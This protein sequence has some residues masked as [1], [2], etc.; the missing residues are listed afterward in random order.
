MT[1]RFL[2]SLGV[3]AFTSVAVFGQANRW[4]AEVHPAVGKAIERSDEAVRTGEH[5]LAIALLSG[6]LY[7]DGITVRLDESN[8]QGAGERAR[9]AT[10][11]AVESW[12]R[13][14]GNDSP[15]RLVRTGDSAAVR[16]VLVP[17]LA[18]ESEDALG[19]INLEKSYKW[20]RRSHEVS[21]RGT[22]RVLTHWDGRPLTE[23][24]FTEVIAHELGHLMGLADVS[25]PGPL[26]GPAV[27]GRAVTEPN[28]HEVRILTEL[29]STLRQR[30]NS[31]KNLYDRSSTAE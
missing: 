16:I 10:D 7:P 13:H 12:A 11:R 23:D 5:Q 19:F 29:R 17:S 18:E 1:H 31:A 25:R 26:M 9:R 27:K 2:L 28:S 6:S 21:V 3:F 24:E 15:I 22:I 8:L 14:L 30:W 4:P 20:N